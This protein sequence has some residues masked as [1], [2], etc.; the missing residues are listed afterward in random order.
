MMRL[1]KFRQIE[2]DEAELG[3]EHS[4]PSSRS[5]INHSQSPLLSSSTRAFAKDEGMCVGVCVGGWGPWEGPLML[6]AVVV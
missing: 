1:M 3:A 6:L 2:P 4:A 5:S